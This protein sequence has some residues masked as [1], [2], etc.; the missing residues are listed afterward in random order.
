MACMFIGVISFTDRIFFKSSNDN[1]L[2]KAIIAND[3]TSIATLLRNKVNPNTVD[4]DSDNALMYTALYSSYHTTKLFLDFNANPNL[5]NKAGETV[6]MWAVNDI[7]KEKLL[8]KKGADVNIISS[9]GN[10][11]LLIAATSQG[12]AEVVHLL[13]ENNA[14]PIAKNKSGETLLI[15][16]AAG[17]D[18]TILRICLDKNIPVNA[19]NLM[20][21]TALLIAAEN[22]NLQAVKML[23][24]KGADPNIADNSKTTPL[25]FC[26]NLDDINLLNALLEKNADVNLKDS[27]G[28]T[29]LMWAAYNEH[30]NPEIIRAILK[31]GAEIN[32]KANDSSTALSWAMKKGNTKTVLLLKQSGAK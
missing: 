20:G 32:A 16:T 26:A 18:T 15:R 12:S 19:A 11:A 22:D 2:L 17:G 10:T 21:Q 30:D 31:R 25:M 28:N 5:K 24:A 29:A 13:L 4:D 9:S 27:E 3:T 23:L 7:E 8:I 1:E 6:L 14:D